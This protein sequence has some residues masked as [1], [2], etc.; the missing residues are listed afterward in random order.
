MQSELVYLDCGCILLVGKDETGK[1]YQG[2]INLCASHI[3]SN[4]RASETSFRGLLETIM[5]WHEFRHLYS[6]MAEGLH[7]SF[8]QTLSEDNGRALEGASFNA[9][10]SH[11]IDLLTKLKKAYERE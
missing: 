9:K 10:F 3:V 1:T 8:E 2:K 6:E 11:V 4:V 5:P 7:D